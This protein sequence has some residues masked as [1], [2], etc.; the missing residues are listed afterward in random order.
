MTPAEHLVRA[1]E[2]IKDGDPTTVKL[3]PYLDTANV[4]TIGWGHVVRDA[5]GK[6][7]RGRERRRD[8]RAVYPGGI[9]LAEAEIILRD[10]LRPRE[11]AVAKAV[12]GYDLVGDG[13]VGELVRFGVLVS[14]TFNVGIAGFLGSS[15]LRAIRAGDL[16]RVPA[17]LILWNKERKTPGGPLV[18][19]RGLTN[20]RRAEGR[21]WSEGVLP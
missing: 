1:F 11:A 9:T 7:I 6:E 10:D 16:E 13:R 3:D 19:N 21:A 12:R 18:V 8:A 4:W 2:S 14:F 20:R 5:R 17:A 15:V